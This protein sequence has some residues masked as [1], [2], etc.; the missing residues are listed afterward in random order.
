MCVC[1]V[2]VGPVIGIQLDE[3]D[4]KRGSWLFE[5]NTTEYGEAIHGKFNR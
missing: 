3:L 1:V 2:P 5:Q 4:Y